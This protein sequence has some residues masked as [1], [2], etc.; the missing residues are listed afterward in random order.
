MSVNNRLRSQNE[1]DMQRKSVKFVFNDQYLIG[2]ENEPIAVALLANGIKAIRF[3]ET[4]G[5][6]RG[7]YCG[8]GHCYECRAVVNGVQGVRTCVTL[9]HEGTRISSS[10][11]GRLEEE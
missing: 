1:S 7:I 10:R 3:D 8:I 9:L 11:P 5:E 4:L 2:Y 6:P